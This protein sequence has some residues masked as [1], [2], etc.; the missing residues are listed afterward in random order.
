MPFTPYH[1]G[2]GLLLKGL[3][4]RHFSFVAFAGTQVVIDLETLYSMI[5]GEYPLHR[6]FHSLVGATVIGVLV[7]VTVAALG[8]MFKRWLPSGIGPTF[9]A[10][11]SI[12]G[13]LAGGLVGGMSHPVLD[14]LVHGDILVFW[15]VRDTAVQVGIVSAP[16]LHLSCLLAGL[17]G[18]ILW[19]ARV[20]RWGTTS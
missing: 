4:P 10:E 16:V 20:H 6:T 3:G 1:F 12:I 11:L 7:G 5:I 19:W 15:P 2:P 18:V 8:M 14:S 17:V 9:R 13:A